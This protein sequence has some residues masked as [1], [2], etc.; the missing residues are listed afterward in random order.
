MK[1]SPDKYQKWSDKKTAAN[2]KEAEAAPAEE[3]HWQRPEEEGEYVVEE[4]AAMAAEK[5]RAVQEKLQQVARMQ[6]ELEELRERNKEAGN[7][8]QII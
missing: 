4:P 2:A 3:E 6:D 8:H 5:E 1:C 7:S